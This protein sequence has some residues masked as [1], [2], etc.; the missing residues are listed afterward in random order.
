MAEIHVP[1]SLAALF[2]GLP[3][4]VEVEGRDLAAI[5]RA[6]DARYP[7]LWERLCEPGPGLRRHINAFVDGQPATLATTVGEASVVHLIPAISGGTDEAVAT[8]GDGGPASGGST[9]NEGRD[10]ARRPA[11]ARPRSV[12]D[13]GQRVHLETTAQWA[14]WL[15]AN[16]RR[17][18]G[19]WLVQWKS[20]T[21]RPAIP[22]EEA[23]TEALRFGWVD[24]TYRSLDAERGML[25][26]SP[27]RKGSY[28]ARTNRDRVARLEAEGRMAEAG[29]AAVAAAQAD[30]SW[31]LL[32]PVEALVVPDDLAEALAARPGAR[33]RWDA[34]PP[35][36]RRAFL[37]WLVTARRE[38]T[39]AARV[40]E[41]ADLVAEG[42]RLEERR[43]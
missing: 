29:R 28:W 3:R 10:E 20:R 27:R 39:R 25:W 11:G 42:K 14:A 37:L 21:G 15:E 17:R 16:H 1:R 18:T 36:A 7:G 23:I 6:L 41:T 43:R 5:L 38:A 9:T 33:E 35:T 30:G 2:P 34:L 12:L 13:D 31:T 24:S 4:R 40:A 19:V 22:Y 26:W 8:A 32:E